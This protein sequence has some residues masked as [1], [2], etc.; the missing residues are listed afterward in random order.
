MSSVGA[1]ALGASGQISL[2]GGELL[3]GDVDLCW[4]PEVQTGCHQVVKPRAK[5][6]G[7]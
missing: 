7:Y 2:G 6:W 3:Y 4:L 5:G 1:E